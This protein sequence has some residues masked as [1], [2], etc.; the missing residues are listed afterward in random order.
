MP[1]VAGVVQAASVQAEPSGWWPHLCWELLVLSQARGLAASREIWHHRS[2]WLVES[3]W[4]WL[5]E[6]PGA[7]CPQ[8]PAT[9]LLPRV[10]RSWALIQKYVGKKKIA[11]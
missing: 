10:S 8:P 7:L 3:G 1:W 11:E 4:L 6:Q 5:Q 2:L 9:F